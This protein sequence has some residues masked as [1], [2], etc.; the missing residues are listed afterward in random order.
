M[1]EPILVSYSILPFY[2]NF[3]GYI[4]DTQLRYQSLFNDEFQI[5]NHSIQPT[6]LGW[7]TD[8]MVLEKYGISDDKPSTLVWMRP[9]AT[10]LIQ[11]PVGRLCNLDGSLASLRK[12]DKLEITIDM[13]YSHIDAGDADRAILL[14]PDQNLYGPGFAISLLV[15]TPMFFIFALFAVFRDHYSGARSYLKLLRRFGL[16]PSSNPAPAAEPTANERRPL[17]HS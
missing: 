10:P 12:G 4:R 6:S 14:T 16:A 1:K 13:K 3:N 9:A 15:A 8:A 2:Q 17:I 5:S 7:E 11:K